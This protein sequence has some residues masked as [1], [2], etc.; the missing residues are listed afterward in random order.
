MPLEK[1]LR[2]FTNNVE[3][4]EAEH[5]DPHRRSR[6]GQSLSWSARSPKSVATRSNDR[7]EVRAR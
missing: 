7:S 5:G 1:A 6:V 4:I 2:C 3:R